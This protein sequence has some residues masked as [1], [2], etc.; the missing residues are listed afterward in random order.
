[1]VAVTDI[2]GNVTDTLKYDAYGSVSER[3]GDSALIFGYNGQYGV[4]TDPN[5]L[6]Y[7]RTRFYNPHL[8]RFMNADIIDGSIADSTSLNL[9]T[10]VNGNPISFVDPFGL[11]AERGG[12]SVPPQISPSDFKAGIRPGLYE[13]KWYLDYTDVIMNRINEVLPN[14]ESHRIQPYEDYIENSSVVLW[15]WLNLYTPGF[16]DYFAHIMG[17]LWFFYDEVKTG[18]PWDVK[19]DDPW[20]QQFG[21]E[22]T[23]PYYYPGHDD[24]NEAFLFR[25]ELVYRDNLGNITYGYLGSAMGIGDTTLRWGGGVATYLQK[26]KIWEII[27]GEIQKADNYGDNP[28]DSEDVMKGVKLFFADYPDAKIGFNGML[29]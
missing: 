23:M 7:M 27:N 8:K 25:G 4:L 19:L 5:G 15:G 1:M 20:R 28:G 2:D 17:N 13:G 10:F 16:D 14:F 21:T 29:P 11:S 3:T 18:G 22:I 6:L 24:L 26:G 9:Y 12:V